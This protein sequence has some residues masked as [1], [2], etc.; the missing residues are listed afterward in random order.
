MD[1]KDWKEVEEDDKKRKSNIIGKYGFNIVEFTEE[2]LKQET[3]EK[4][5]KRNN[6]IKLIIIV[7]I[8]FF[9]LLRVSIVNKQ[10]AETMEEKLLSYLEKTYNMDFEILFK[11]T[12]WKGKGFYTIAL[13]NTPEL[14]FNCVISGTD[15]ENSF[16]SDFVSRYYKYYFE[17]WEDECKS[18][19]VE[20]EIY[21]DNV[22]KFIK[23][24]NSHLTYYTYIEVSNYDELLV[25]VN[26]IIKF[27][28][29]VGNRDILIG[30][31]IKVK[32]QLIIPH[33]TMGETN[34]EIID[35]AIKQYQDI[36]ETRN[37]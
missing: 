7:L 21:E 36:M 2:R 22:Y 30:S 35:N 3:I 25:A 24:K 9:V 34:E 12:Y 8:I 11:K 10:E 28:E 5:R 4:I 33:G 37:K 26:D 1:N 16:S 14:K 29:Y 6:I 13:K 19:F 17:K 32:G 20:N 23:E 27:V 31:Y 18:N 15:F